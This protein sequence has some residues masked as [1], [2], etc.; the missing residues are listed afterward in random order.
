[1]S[2]RQQI[3]EALAGGSKTINQITTSIGFPARNLVYAMMQEKI[4]QPGPKV[5]DSETRRWVRV[6]SLRS[7]HQEADNIMMNLGRY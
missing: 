6:F 2:G 3:I 1:M 4:L 7:S 5:I